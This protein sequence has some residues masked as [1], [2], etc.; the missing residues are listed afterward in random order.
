MATRKSSAKT[1]GRD[2]P[3]HEKI[4]R[5]AANHPERTYSEHIAASRSLLAE[6][7]AQDLRR[8][9]SRDS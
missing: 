7:Y 1:E 9:L 5:D 4:R 8:L 2:I 3:A 6:Q